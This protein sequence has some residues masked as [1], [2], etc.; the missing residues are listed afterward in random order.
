MQAKLFQRL[1]KCLNESAKWII[2][3]YKTPRLNN[4]C[5]YIMCMFKIKNKYNCFPIHLSNETFKKMTEVFYEYIKQLFIFGSFRI[6]GKTLWRYLNI[7]F[8]YR[9]H[10]CF[11]CWHHPRCI[12]L[13]LFGINNMSLYTITDWAKHFIVQCIVVWKVGVR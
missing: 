5:G 2:L 9:L 11:L 10:Q 3:N 1:F 6:K 7:I 13:L 4:W 8:V 12:F